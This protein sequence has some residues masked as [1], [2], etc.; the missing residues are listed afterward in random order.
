[1]VPPMSPCAH[2]SGRQCSPS[3]RPHPPSPF[4]SLARGRSWPIVPSFIQKVPNGKTC[5]RQPHLAHGT[6]RAL[7]PLSD[8]QEGASQSGSSLVDWYAPV[9]AIALST[10]PCAEPAP[11]VRI[12]PLGADQRS[13]GAYKK[14]KE[15]ESHDRNEPGSVRGGRARSAAAPSRSAT[16]LRT[17]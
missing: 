17:Y 2:V 12:D 10:A 14:P 9:V 1:M 7:L 6:I 4:P 11:A 13:S 5:R 3:L 16:K 15:D 8:A